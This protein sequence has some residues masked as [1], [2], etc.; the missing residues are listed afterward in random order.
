MWRFQAHI[1]MSHVFIF[2]SMKIK[3]MKR[4][5]IQKRIAMNSFFFFFLTSNQN[6]NI[7]SIYH[8]CTCTKWLCLLFI[9]SISAKNYTFL[10]HATRSANDQ[11]RIL[12]IYA[13]HWS[14]SI[15][16]KI[17]KCKF[18]YWMQIEI[19]KCFQRFV[20]FIMTDK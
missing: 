1:Q 15:I 18:Y 2:M 13:H 11:K 6:N 19:N 4:I 20:S 9:C 3:R 12:Y 7:Y 5:K 8:Q 14:N 16:Y 17:M 10:F